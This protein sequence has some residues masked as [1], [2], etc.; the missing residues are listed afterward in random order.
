M[1]T[2]SACHVLGILGVSG[3]VDVLALVIG[4]EGVDLEF[5][6][7]VEDG[8]LPGADPLAAGFRY[9]TLAQVVVIGAPT[10]SIPCLQHDEI[11]AAGALQV[12]RRGQAG[13][14][15]TD[16]CDVQHIIVG[17][18]RRLPDSPPAERQATDQSRAA[19]GLQQQASLALGGRQF[20]VV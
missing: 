2:L 12:P 3:Q 1:V 17:A 5:A 19:D 7:Q 20:I 13:Q 11:L 10:D 9:D 18:C 16:D 15:G 6:R 8:S 4:R 14:A